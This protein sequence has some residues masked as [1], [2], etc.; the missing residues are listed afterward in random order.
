[1]KNLTYSKLHEIPRR[2]LNFILHERFPSIIHLWNTAKSTLSISSTISSGVTQNSNLK[3]LTKKIFDYIP[4]RGTLLTCTELFH[5]VESYSAD[6]NIYAVVS[7]YYI[8]LQQT[9]KKR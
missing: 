9:L 2:P 3:N 5:L 6:C 8:K 1:M 4:V 7:M